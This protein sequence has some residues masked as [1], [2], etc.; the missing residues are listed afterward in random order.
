MKHADADALLQAWREGIAPDPVLTVS[1][2]ADRHYILSDNSAEPGPWRTD[3]TPYLREPMDRTGATDRCTK[4]TFVKPSQVGGSEGM[5]NIPIGYRIACAPVPILMV[6]PKTEAAQSY[7]RDRIAPM[8][9]ACPALRERVADPKARDSGNTLS[10]KEFPGGF[11]AMCGANSPADLA[12]RPIGVVAFD[13]TDRFSHSAGTEGDAI[14]LA[15][16]RTIT[17]PRRKLIYNSSPNGNRRWSRIFR[18][19]E[20][21]DQ[22]QYWLPCPH[23]HE[24]FLLLWE[25]MAW[26]VGEDG[27]LDRDSVHHPCPHCGSVIENRHKAYMLPRGRWLPT[28]LEDGEWVHSEPFEVDHY[29]YWINGLYAPVGWRGWADIVAEWIEVRGDPPRAQQFINT[30][31]LPYDD[32]GETIDATG[33]QQRCEDYVAEVPDGAVVLVAAVDVQAD[34]LELKVKGYGLGK[35]TWLI[36]YRV[37]PGDPEYDGVWDALDEALLARYATS[38]GGSLPIEAACID[39][40]YLAERVYRF[41]K[42]RWRRNVWAIKGK[43]GDRDIWPIKWSKATK[44]D[45]LKIKIVGVDKAK[46]HIFARLAK[47][48]DGDAVMHF[49]VTLPGNR[50]LPDWYFRQLVSEVRKPTVRNGRKAWR[51]VLPDGARNEA[52]D[53][54]VYSYAA[55]LGWLSL[56]S[57]EVAAER[58][59]A[60][61]LAAPQQ[62][63]PRRRDK[64]L[65]QRTARPRQRAP[66]PFGG[67][68]SRG[69]SPW[70]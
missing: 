35:E 29:G 11:L 7:S 30:L 17:F 34:R 1:E 33:L 68:A 40:G 53:L 65:P 23:C 62:R 58:R 4:V 54:E 16:K 69:R 26:D 20:D 21:S 63:A 48:G 25:S 66:S 14:G 42:P 57:M 36:D 19:Y 28:H 24:L 41:C 18:Q 70:G 67:R 49:P 61:T 10:R 56:R 60:R 64:P 51:W 37:L 22:R 50:P 43:A 39:S 6:Q 46:D 3:R 59:E 31:G 5:I 52:L 12:S 38:N 47:T 15:E 2:W 27:A 45:R 32:D 55:V 9:A 13:E 8:I 44:N